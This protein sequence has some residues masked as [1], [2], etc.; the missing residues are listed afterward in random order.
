[1]MG[2]GFRR[3]EQGAQRRV[4]APSLDNSNPWRGGKALRLRFASL[5]ATGWVLLTLATPAFAQTRPPT[6]T[7]R[8]IAMPFDGEWVGTAAAS[9]SC[10]ALTIRLTIEGGA[11]DGTALEPDAPG[12]RVVGKRGE[13]MPVPPAL[14]QLHG[15]V[16]TDGTIKIAGLRSMKERDRQNASWSGRAAAATITLTE[17]GAGCSRAAT[18]SRGR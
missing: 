2:S 8:I 7:D 14:W 13:T 15:R 16:Q 1:M 11:I 18:L 12:T 6:V 10:A 5:R 9:G 3:P 17:S 4:E